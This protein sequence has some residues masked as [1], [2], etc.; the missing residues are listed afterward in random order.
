MNKPSKENKYTFKVDNGTVSGYF[1]IRQVKSGKILLMMGNSHTELTE[2]QL[3][4]LGIDL[5]LL[6]DFSQEEYNRAYKQ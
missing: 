3:G 4:E 5:Y 6:D 2:N 1:D